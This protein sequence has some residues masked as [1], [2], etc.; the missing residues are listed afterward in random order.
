MDTEEINKKITSLVDGELEQADIVK[1]IKNLIE[2][3]SKINFY[4]NLQKLMKSVI[5]ERMEIQ[6]APE[7][8]RKKVIRKIKPF[9]F[10]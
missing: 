5:S 4:Y 3:N 8:I 9:K 7:R 6:S 10:F 2:N 1:E